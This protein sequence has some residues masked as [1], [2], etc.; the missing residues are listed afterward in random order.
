MAIK[1]IP[2]N[3]RKFIAGLAVTHTACSMYD[4]DSGNMI[5]TSAAYAWRALE[6]HR[7]ARLTESS[8]G[9]TYTVHVHSNQ[10]YKLTAAAEITED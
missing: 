8:D 3:R 7:H 2:R 4:Q 6:M 10:W 5:T 1:T 9:T